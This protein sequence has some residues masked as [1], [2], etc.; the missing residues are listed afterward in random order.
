[1]TNDS[2]RYERGWNVLTRVNATERPR[3][4]EQVAEVAPD[5]ARWIVE[6]GY[7]EV[8]DRPTLDEGRRQLVT[9][10]ALAALGGCEAQLDVHVNVALNVGVPPDEIVE[11]VLH[12]LPFIGFPRTIN[13][14]LVVRAVFER[15]GVAPTAP[16]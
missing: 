10:G 1:M 5:L 15:R 12:T 16:G 2:D 13:A 3:V 7:G 11:A 6:F 14:M 4:V 8:Y 9:I